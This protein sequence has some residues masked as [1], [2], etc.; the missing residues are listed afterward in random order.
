MPRLHIER[1]RAAMHATRW[2]APIIMAQA[3]KSPAKKAAK[4]AAKKSPAKKAAK[5]SPAKKAA[6]KAAK[7]SPAKKAAKRSS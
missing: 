4:K 2:E 5:K 7:K 3:K 1:R 6:K